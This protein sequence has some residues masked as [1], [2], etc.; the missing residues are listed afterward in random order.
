MVRV[1]SLCQAVI[2]RFT[3]NMYEVC[4]HL[5]SL[6]FVDTSGKYV[7][8]RKNIVIICV[9]GHKTVI[10]MYLTNKIITLW[11]KLLCERSHTFH[12]LLSTSKTRQSHRELEQWGFSPLPC[13]VEGAPLVG[14]K[15]SSQFQFLKKQ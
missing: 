11:G 3:I 13:G 14:Q 15:K 4:C 6:S 9:F 5:H 10:K 8:F 1:I 7:F 12:S 2:L